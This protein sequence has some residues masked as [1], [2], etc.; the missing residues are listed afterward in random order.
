MDYENEIVVSDS[1][2]REKNIINFKEG[3][4]KS[5][6]EISR[7]LKDKKYFLFASLTIIPSS[8]RRRIISFGR[9]LRLT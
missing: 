6:S 1:S 3:I 4:D 2:E 7:V 8:L 5:I 9:K